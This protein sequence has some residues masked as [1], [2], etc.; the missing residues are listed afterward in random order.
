MSKKNKHLLR[1][2]LD[3]YVGVL[4][5][6]MNRTEFNKQTRSLAGLEIDLDTVDGYTLEDETNHVYLMYYNNKHGMFHELCHV[7]LSLFN[8]VG[9]DPREANGEPMAYMVGYLTRTIEKY[10]KDNKLR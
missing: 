1:I 6:A 5:V 4:F 3:P 7:V 10:K 2:D 9:I 8:H